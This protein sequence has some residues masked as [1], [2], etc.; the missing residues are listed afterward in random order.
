MNSCCRHRACRS[1]MQERGQTGRSWPEGSKA[2]WINHSNTQG[3]VI[4]HR[5]WRPLDNDLESCSAFK[6]PLGAKA[7]SNV[8]AHMHPHSPVYFHSFVVNSMY[9]GSSLCV[10]MKL[11][12]LT[13]AFLT[14]VLN[15]QSLQLSI[16]LRFRI[17]SIP[18]RLW[19]RLVISL[20][21]METGQM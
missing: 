3:L 5:S 16:L 14:S 4:G 21:L 20:V 15:V 17:F 8:H 9:M 13:V 19:W 6:R 10:V 12:F 18:G 7:N 1:R 2:N 11:I